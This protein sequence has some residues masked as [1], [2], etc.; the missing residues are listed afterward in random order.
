MSQVQQAQIEFPV[1]WTFRIILESAAAAA[2][3]PV[4]RMVFAG[5]GKNPE[6]VEGRGSAGGKYATWQA[7]VTLADRRELEE[8]PK[9]LSQVPGVRMVL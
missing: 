9:Q 5:F 2:A 8:L 1:E 3:L 7:Q 6:L 4:L